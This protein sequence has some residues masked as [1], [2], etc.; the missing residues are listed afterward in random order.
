[1]VLRIKIRLMPIWIMLQDVAPEKIC[2]FICY[3]ENSKQRLMTMGIDS[4]K[5]EVNS[6]AYY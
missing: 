2:S 1:M 4:N 5:I 6:Q 3:D